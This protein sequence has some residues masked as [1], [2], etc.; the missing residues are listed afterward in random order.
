MKDMVKLNV[1]SSFCV[2]GKFL[3]VN[4]I[5]TFNGEQMV[6][7]VWSCNGCLPRRDCDRRYTLDI[8]EAYGYTI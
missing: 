5:F 1:G 8:L 6:E 2:A 3:K 4:K 7:A